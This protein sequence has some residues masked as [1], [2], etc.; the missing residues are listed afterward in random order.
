[1]PKRAYSIAFK[2]VVIEF[3]QD[4]NTAWA[5]AKHFSEC[6]KTYVM[7]LHYVTNGTKKLIKSYRP[8]LQRK[9]FQVKV[10]NQ[11]WG[12]GGNS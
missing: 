4:G 9:V 8:L 2:K 12:N 1:M 7:T 6:D 3:M 10:K 5:A 11:F